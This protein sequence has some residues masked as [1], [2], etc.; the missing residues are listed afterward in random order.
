MIIV[1]PDAPL[2]YANAESVRDSVESAVT[3]SDSPVHAV[4]L[5][6]DANDDLDIT[7]AEQLEKLTESLIGRDVA[8]TLVHL[9]K[10]AEKMLES[11]GLLE[12]IGRDH[13][14]PNLASAVEWAEHRT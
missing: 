7:S 5:D 12:K 11:T 13:L 14:F 1:R 10:P 8:V 2:F 4:V 6:L 3:A 9:H